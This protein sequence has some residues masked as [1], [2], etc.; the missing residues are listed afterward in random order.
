LAKHGRAEDRRDEGLAHRIFL[1]FPFNVLQGVYSVKKPDS[2]PAVG[3]RQT[4]LALENRLARL[5][6]A[7][8]PFNQADFAKLTGI[9]PSMIAHYEI[10]K[11]EKPSAAHLEAMAHVAGITIEEGI[12]L[13]HLYESRR[14]PRLRPGRAPDASFARLGEE[15]R[16]RVERIYQSLL[17]LPNPGLEAQSRQRLEEQMTLLRILD[18]PARSSAVKSAR[19]FQTVALAERVAAEAA[20][21]GPRNHGASESWARLAKEIVRLAS[22]G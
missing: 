5:F 11:G 17:R 12:D 2:L 10:G 16:A 20:A 14:Q 9:H 19:T 8:T 1:P 4:E 7:L 18:E 21:A 22:T 6:R 3:E 15:I 13:L